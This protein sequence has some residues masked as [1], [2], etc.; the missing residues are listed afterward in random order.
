MKSY[1]Q[2]LRILEDKKSNNSLKKENIV[3]DT[4]IS[5][6]KSKR[7]PSYIK[8]HTGEDDMKNYLD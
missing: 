1:S 3:D 8:I 6:K 4:L 7:K 2:F 5:K